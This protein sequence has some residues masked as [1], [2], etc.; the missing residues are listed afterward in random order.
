MDLLTHTLTGAALSRAGL[1]RWCPRALPLLLLA[2]NA[3]DID[4]V[5]AAGG[6]LAY[7][8]GHRHL[9]HAL[10][11]APLLAA[12]VAVLVLAVRPSQIDARR[13][14]WRMWLVALV[15]VLTHLLLDWTNVYG[16]RLLLPF[17]A[18]WFRLDSVHIADPWIWLILASAFAAPFVSRLVSAEIGAKATPGRGA[19]IFALVLLL[20][21]TGGRTQLHNRAVATLESRLY[22]GAAPGRVIA[23]PSAVNPLRWTGL[24]ETASFWSVQEVNLLGEF[25]P[26]AGRT[27]Y[28]PD[29]MKALDDAG[30]TRTF[31]RFLDFSQAPYWRVLPVEEPGQGV[32]VEALDLRFGMPVRPRFYVSALLDRNGA[33]VDERFRFGPLFPD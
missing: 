30:K 2:A 32:R 13:N 27:L 20:G 6:E 15:G 19:A 21:Y 14:W 9:T 33:V 10:A 28:K 8:D 17:S 23:L 24:V 29:A 11:L 3:P 31:Q 1:D 5:T 22:A 25:D 16:V 12:A 18:Q 4:I 7:L 26:G